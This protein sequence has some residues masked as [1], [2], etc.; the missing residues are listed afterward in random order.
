VLKRQSERIENDSLRFR[1]D[2]EEHRGAMH[3]GGWHRIGEEKA[4]DQKLTAIAETAVK[5]A[6][7]KPPAESLHKR[8]IARAPHGRGLFWME[9]VPSCPR[10][11]G[12]QKQAG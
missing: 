11:D 2:S 10:C 6:R 12:E 1:P 7:R 3:L 5:S 9:P 4:A 8:G